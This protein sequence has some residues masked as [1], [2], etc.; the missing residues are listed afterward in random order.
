MLNCV[1]NK[2]DQ[3]QNTHS[4]YPP[5]K[6]VI[7]YQKKNLLKKN[8]QK[9]ANISQAK[10]CKLLGKNLKSIGIHNVE[11]KILRIKTTFGY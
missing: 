9:L 5:I 2:L 4:P 8:H 1:A 7:F 6:A 10:K 11:K 3:T